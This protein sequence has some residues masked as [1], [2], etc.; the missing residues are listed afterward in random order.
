MNSR[1][2]YIAILLVALCALTFIIQPTAVLPSDARQ[3]PT[4]KVRSGP[5]GNITIKVWLSDKSHHIW[6]YGAQQ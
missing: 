6:V 4:P 1:T 3:T 5:V 2:R